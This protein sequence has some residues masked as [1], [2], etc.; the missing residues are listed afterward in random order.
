MQ[1]KAM[2]AK[3]A[4]SKT[5]SVDIEGKRFELRPDTPFSSDVYVD[6]VKL[7][8]MFSLNYSGNVTKLHPSGN[9]SDVQKERYLNVM[10]NYLTKHPEVLP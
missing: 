7:P 6:G 5:Y 9:P 4:N 3:K 10:S 8:G 1:L 2:M